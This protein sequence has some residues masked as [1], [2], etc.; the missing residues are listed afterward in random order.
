[1]HPAEIEESLEQAVLLVDT[2]EQETAALHRRL[3][4][5]GLPWERQKLNA[6]DYS[7]KCPL[8]D[9]CTLDLSETV[10]IERKMSLDELAMCFGTQ[11][12][13]F[14][15]EFDRATEAGTRL[16]LLIEDASWEKIFKHEYRSRLSEKALVASIVAFQARYGSPVILCQRESTGK[17]IREILLKEMKERLK[18][19]GE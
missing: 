19:Y 8:P 7:L 10:A 2:R 1:M 16:Y 5:T 15:A 11:R 9:G 6:G 18:A 13:R 12:K 4:Q 3:D 14:T 17:L